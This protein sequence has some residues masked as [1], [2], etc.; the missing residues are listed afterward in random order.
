MNRTDIPEVRAE[1]ISQKILEAIVTETETAIP[2]ASYR[3]RATLASESSYIIIR[4]LGKS[5][6][7]YKNYPLQ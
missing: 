2:S 1:K 5:F 4:E 7:M 6:A 3:A